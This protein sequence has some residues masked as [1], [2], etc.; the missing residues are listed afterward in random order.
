M[1]LLEALAQAIRW[2][3]LPAFMATYKVSKEWVE[4]VRNANGFQ[5]FLS[6]AA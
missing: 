3:S 4:S 1:N 5:I 2:N 6:K